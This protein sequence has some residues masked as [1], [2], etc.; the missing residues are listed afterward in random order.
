MPAY[1]RK[2]T[3]SEGN[4]L[5]WK[6]GETKTVK[7]LSKDATSRSIH[8]IGGKSQ[9]CLGEDCPYC[10][11]EDT[12]RQRWSLDV[13]V[14]GA[15]TIWDMSNQVFANIEDI[16]E[17]VGYLTDLVLMVKRV[18]SGMN[19][20][21]ALVPMVGDKV[22]ENVLDS[23]VGLAK[24]IKRLCAIRDTDPKDELATFLVNISPAHHELPTLDQLKGLLAYLQQLVHD[25]KTS[26]DKEPESGPDAA[27]YF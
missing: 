24:E 22:A 23:P 18:G 26:P 27:S 5:K 15:Q 16:A 11:A 2:S 8:W 20:T 21:Y 6:A 13:E 10:D 14:E 17:M 25:P 9:D 12:P 1:K 7:I 4:F 19:T 3:H